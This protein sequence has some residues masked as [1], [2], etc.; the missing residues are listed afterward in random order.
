M[1]YFTGRGGRFRKAFVS[2]SWLSLLDLLGKA[3]SCAKA[4]RRGIALQNRR[5]QNLLV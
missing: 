5:A 4:M 2:R 1:L 3:L